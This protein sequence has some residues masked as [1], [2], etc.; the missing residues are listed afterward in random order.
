MSLHIVRRA[1]AAVAVSVIVIIGAG[2]A[3][4]HLPALE[5]ARSR[6]AANLLSS[7]L[8]EAVVVNGGVDVTLGQTI[9][10]AVQGVG[11]AAS[12]APA[13]TAPVGTMRM[14][15]SL[16][17]ALRGRLDLTALDLSSVRLIIN[18]AEPSKE[19]LGRSVSNAVERVL[20]S[21]LLPNLRLTDVRILRINDPAGWNGSLLF[22]TVTS[23]ETDRAG[24]VSLDAKGSLNGQAFRLPESFRTSPRPPE[25]SATTAY[26]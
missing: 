4:L 18:A 6:I 24:A 9:D 17:A 23:R 11:P 19:S 20:S 5:D 12:A 16:D 2:F 15:F 1:L 22:N 13:A 26:R 14:S 7:Y 3:F 21:P 25:R 8:G 10:V